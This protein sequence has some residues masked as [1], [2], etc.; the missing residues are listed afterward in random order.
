M[1][2]W[3]LN[4][5]KGWRFGLASIVVLVLLTVGLGA[6]IALIPVSL[7]TFMLVIGA[8]A[9]LMAAA[10]VGYALWGLLNAEYAMD[11][12][13]LIIRWGGYTHQI[14]MAEVQAVLSGAE[15]ERV[16]FNRVLRWPGYVV[17]QGT[18]AEIGPI[19]FYASA[20][21]PEQIVLQLDS[22]A[23][24]ISP[25]DRALFLEALEERLEMGATLDVVHEIAHPAL[26]DWTIWRDRLALGLLGSNLLL[27]LL[28]SGLLSWRYASL[29]PSIV[30]KVDPTGTPLL[31]GPPSRLAY[32]GLLGVLFT[33]VNGG[34]G[35]IFYRRR[36]MIAY[37]L[38]SGLLLLLATL[39]IAILSILFNL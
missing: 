35:L 18:A 26:L 3:D 32:L 11:R 38:W 15:L 2:T 20:P 23:Y 36:P 24:A 13:T 16:R 19:F 7:L 28:L 9:T 25:A 10:Y 22:L 21:L 27:L 4:I 12:N 30:L 8:L 6:L 31:V 37:F 14:P 29:P 33:V 39:W 1:T 5:Q 34:L 17:G